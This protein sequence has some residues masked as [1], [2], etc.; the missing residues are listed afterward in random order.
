[1]MSIIAAV[2][3]NLGIA[4]ESGIPWRDQLPSDRAFFRNTIKDQNILMARKTYAEL[5]QPLGKGTNFVLTHH[6]RDIRPGFEAVTDLDQFLNTHSEQVWNIGGA[7]LYQQTLHVASELVLTRIKYDF[8]CTKF[9]P[10][11]E[12]LFQL[13]WQSPIL[14][15]SHIQYVFQRWAILEQPKIPHQT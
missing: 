2:D 5:L 4:N 1:M 6:P 9:F 15:E 7:D 8:G 3:Q 14:V 11:F 12:N 10:E 13:A